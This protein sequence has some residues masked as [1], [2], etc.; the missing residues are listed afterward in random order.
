MDKT[1]KDMG[2]IYVIGLGPGDVNM[3]TPRAAEALDDCDVVIG[4]KVYIDLIRDI[5]A[6]KELIESSMREEIKR[7]KACVEMA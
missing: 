7:C 1:G 3:M 5:C 2:K 6:G 4:Y